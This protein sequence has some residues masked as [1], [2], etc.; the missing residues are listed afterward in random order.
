[1]KN[2][3]RP[4]PSGQRGNG[5]SLDCAIFGNRPPAAPFRPARDCAPRVMRQA[6]PGSTHRFRRGITLRIQ[7]R[8]ACGSPLE[9][10]RFRLTLSPLAPIRSLTL[11]IPSPRLVLASRF[12]VH[13]ASRKRTR[14]PMLTS[15]PS[16][17]K[18]SRRPSICSIAE[19]K[20]TRWLEGRGTPPH[21]TDQPKGRNV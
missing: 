6:A 16:G 3:T 4:L 13:F 10:A 18:T 9:A 8:T 17:S 19:R 20:A 12:V 15:R 5:V 2:I 21:V 1:M 7:G 14:R 11:P